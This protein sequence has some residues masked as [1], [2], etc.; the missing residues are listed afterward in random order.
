MNQAQLGL[1]DVSINAELLRRPFRAPDYEA[2][3]H[4]LT[5]L[6]QTVANAPDTILQKLAETALQLCRAD[7]AGISLLDQNDG[8]EVFRLEALA[9][10]FSDRRHATMPRDVSPCGTTIDRN[11]TQLM[12]MA[13]RMFPAL[14]SVPPM[15][16]A[17][18]IP[19]HVANVPIGTVWVV[20]HDERRKFDQE[21]ERIIKTLAQFAS[22]CWQLWRTRA[23]ALAEIKQE[24]Q[25][26][27]DM[28]ATNVSLQAQLEN[29]GRVEEELQQCNRDLQLQITESTA[30]MT[31]EEAAG[32]K[33]A[34][35]VHDFTNLLSVIQAYAGLIMSHPNESNRVFQDAEVI[36]ATIREGVALARQLLDAGREPEAPLELTNVNDLLRRMNQLLLPT[37]PATISLAAD[38]DPGAPMIMINPGLIN[39]AVL[40]LCLNA[41]DAMPHGG[42]LLLQTRMISGA[43]VRARF[44]EASADQ[45]LDISVADTGVGMEPE[46][47][48]RVFELYFTTKK[49]NQGTGLGLSVVRDIVRKHAG[50]IEVN[51]EQ[52]C[53]SSFHIYLPRRQDEA[54]PIDD[55]LLTE[56]N[57]V[58]ARHRETI[59][60]AEDEPSL[61]LLIRR[62]L[63]KEGFNV[64]TAT[65]GAE[66]LEVYARHKDEIAVAILDSGLAKLDGWE[67]FRQ[68]REINPKLKGILAS[69]YVSAAAAARA[70]SGELCGLLPKPYIVED[71]LALVKQAI[72]Q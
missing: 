27:I 67:A 33:N 22:G 68:M 57:D 30:A 4:A 23:V 11:E 16:E 34:G 31:T 70:A 17:L 29:K 1:Q 62:L 19:F 32:G 51:S 53:G 13:E 64:L 41:R 21:D 7:S 54:A 42:K 60:Y 14:T 55:S 72:R 38:F 61:A 28:V 39:Q 47:K 56:Q 8:A 12:Y 45:Y 3:N 35:I 58:K 37:F 18:L 46:V 9:G 2:E 25:R 20:A 49:H 24:R 6:A 48:R 43:T 66:A 52:G 44:L 10:V 69:G 26:A 63:E 36:T 59:L 40:N 15:V 5:A 50:F 65:D 71:V